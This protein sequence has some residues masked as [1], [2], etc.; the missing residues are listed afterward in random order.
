MTRNIFE[1]ADEETCSIADKKHTS[2][3]Y[4]QVNQL[5]QITMHHQNPEYKLG[6]NGEKT[7]SPVFFHDQNIFYLVPPLN[8]NT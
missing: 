8:T 2:M 3:V 4:Q 1:N 7:F 6:R 5:H